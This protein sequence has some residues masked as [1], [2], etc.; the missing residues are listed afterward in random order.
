ML[1]KPGAS[2]CERYGTIPVISLGD[3]GGLAVL[4]DR[5]YRILPLQSPGR[6]RGGGGRCGAGGAG[7]VDCARSAD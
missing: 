5:A 1:S 4:P 3:E 7:G 6:Q 2:C